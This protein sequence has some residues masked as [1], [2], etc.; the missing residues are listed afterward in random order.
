MNSPRNI[1]ITGFGLYMSLSI[2][3]YFTTYMTANNNGPINTSSV[4]FNSGA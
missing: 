2:P 1:F 3:D 4:E